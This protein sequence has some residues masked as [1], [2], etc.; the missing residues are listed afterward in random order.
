MAGVVAGRNALTLSGGEVEGQNTL[1]GHS[2]AGSVGGSLAHYQ[3]DCDQGVTTGTPA[4][5]R[6]TASS[7]A[8]SNGMLGGGIAGGS[9]DILFGTSSYNPVGDEKKAEG[10]EGGEAAAETQ[11]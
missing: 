11:G 7:D 5:D 1:S 8:S 9:V 2:I 6:S 10:G 3:H 4:G